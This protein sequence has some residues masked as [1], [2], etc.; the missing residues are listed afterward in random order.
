MQKHGPSSPR[1]RPPNPGFGSQQR[2]LGA[3]QGFSDGSRQPLPDLP[4]LA[5]QGRSRSN[6]LSP[7]GEGPLRSALAGVPSMVGHGLRVLHIL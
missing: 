1:A 2:P 4:E 7:R 3:D 5:E 6:E